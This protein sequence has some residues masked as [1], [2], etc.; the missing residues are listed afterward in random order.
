M[1]AP[2]SSAEAVSKGPVANRQLAYSVILRDQRIDE[3]EKEID[4]LCLEFISPAGGRNAPLCVR[5]HQINL[6]LG[7]WGT[8]PKASRARSSPLAVPI[9]DGTSERIAEIANPLSRCCTTGERFVNQDPEL[10]R[11]A[12]AAEEAVDR[13]RHQSNAELVKALQGTTPVGALML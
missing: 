3:L 2:R 13:L 4:R 7:G 5:D 8:T 10:A 12:M 11:K 6:E 1:G 9:A